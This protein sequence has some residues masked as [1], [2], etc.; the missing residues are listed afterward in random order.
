[1][2]N[3]PITYALIGV[4]LVFVG[5]P[6]LVI[7]VANRNE[8]AQAHRSPIEIEGLEQA[9]LAELA[10]DGPDDDPNDSD[11]DDPPDEPLPVRPP[12]RPHASTTFPR[13]DSV[14]PMPR[15]SLN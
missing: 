14:P 13:N 8:R 7:F 3:D 12:Q 9:T 5:A 6:A 1:L 11:N 10:G 4:V 2:T 15:D